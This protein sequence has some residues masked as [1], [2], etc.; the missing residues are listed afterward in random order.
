ML[1]T[2]QPNCTI[3][4]IS[5]IYICH[6][7]WHNNDFLIYENAKLNILK[8]SN[9]SIISDDIIINRQIIDSIYKY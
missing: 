4:L 1:E 3:A 6:L 2:F 9:N 5:N 7:D 8:N